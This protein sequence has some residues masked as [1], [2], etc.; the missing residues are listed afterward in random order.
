MSGEAAVAINRPT[1]NREKFAGSQAVIVTYPFFTQTLCPF[2]GPA[3]ICLGLFSMSHMAVL[4][5]NA[6]TDTEVLSPVLSIC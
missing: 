1:Q 5:G 3:L 2:E 4:L 6:S